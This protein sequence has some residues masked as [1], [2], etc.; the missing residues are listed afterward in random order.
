MFLVA[1]RRSSLLSVCKKEKVHPRQRADR[2]EKSITTEESGFE[3]VR[4]SLVN[5]HS[6]LSIVNYPLSI[7]D[8]LDNNLGAEAIDFVEEV[9]LV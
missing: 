5:C 8:L 4:Y 7:K 9:N 6:P 2:Q 3:W 1:K